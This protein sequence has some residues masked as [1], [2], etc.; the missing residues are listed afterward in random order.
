MTLLKTSMIA[1]SC[2]LAPVAAMAQVDLPCSTARVLVG[3]PPGGGTD[4][5]SRVVVDAI[6]AISDGTQLQV[7]N[8]SGQAG[9]RAAGE[10]IDAAGDGCTLFFHHA[11]LLSSYFTG[12]VANNWDAFAPVAMVSFEPAIYAASQNDNFSTLP[13]LV[14]Y[15]SANP[16]AVTAAVSIGSDSHFFALQLQDMMDVELNIV[17]YNGEAER[18]TA[19]LSNVIQ[20]AQVTQQTASQY[21]GNELIPL[22]YTYSERSEDFPDIPTAREAGYDL[23]AGTTRG[24]LMPKDT[25][26][27][28]VQYYADLIEQAMASDAVQAAFER[29]GTI[30]DYRGPEEY[31]EW[32]TQ[33]SDTWEDLAVKLGIFQPRS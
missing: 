12:R 19:L 10:V 5:Q 28:I 18:V 25:S 7:V 22:T 2:C 29:T 11:A 1:L 16:G 31:T 32:W 33:T 23:I 24:F 17:G 26:P 15:A 8:V 13:E 9:N 30:T 4:F 20:F 14:E 27:E 3:F 6:N 21:L